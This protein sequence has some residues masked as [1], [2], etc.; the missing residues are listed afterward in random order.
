MDEAHRYRASAGAQAINE[1]AP[2]LGLE[3]TATPKTTGARP[4]PFRNVVYQYPLARALEDG[5]VKTPAVATRTDFGPERCSDAELERIKLEDGVHHHEFVKVELETYAREHGS[6]LVK[7]FMLVVATDT[8]HARALRALIAAPDFFGGR[9]A[10]RV[11]EVHSALRGDESEEFTQRLLEVEHDERTEIVIHVNK[12]KE[13]WDV[14]NLYTIV[15]LRASASEILTEQT[16]GRGLRLPY[17]RRTGVAALDRPTIIAHDRFQ[18]V[19]ERARDAGS[20]IHEGLTI[21]TG[22]DI[23]D[24]Q[25]QRVTT[26]SLA[27]T[28]LTGKGPS[29][30][31]RP[32]ETPVDYAIE[33]PA[34]CRIAETVL[35]R[36]DHYQHLASVHELTRP[37]VRARISAEVGAE[38]APAQEA[39]E[40]FEPVD[41]ALVARVVER[42]TERLAE[43]TIDIPNIVIVPSREVSYGF[44]DFDLEGLERIH[45]P[46]V[47]EEILV[48]RLDT[49][50]RERI[51]RDPQGPREQR[52]EDYLI[53]VL[54]DQDDIDYDA[55]ADLLY[56]LA[57]QVIGR[58]RSYLAGPA[59][60]EQMARRHRT[61]LARF[62][63]GQLREHHW[64][65]PVGS[66]GRVTRGFT[67]LKPIHFTLDAAER[68]RDFRASL[69]SG[70]PV[71]SL[72]FTGFGK[73]CYPH[74]RFQS[75]EGELSFAR[76]LEREPEVLRW[77]KP[78][79]GQFRIEYAGGAYYEPDFV[80]ETTTAKLIVEPKQRGEIDSEE[81]RA[82]AR[83]ARRWLGYANAHAWTCGGKP[84]RYLLVPHD[85]IG[86][87]R[88]LQGLVA[89]FSQ[90]P[91][92]EEDAVVVA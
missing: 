92:P 63:H 78:A 74:Q 73:C 37:E 10:E 77:M 75:A 47:A 4:Q 68:P 89:E 8:E 69:P 52:P 25:P 1:L 67:A 58:L 88:T 36:I 60:V 82:K 62:I 12:L 23:P 7:P 13:G 91:E 49:G 83:A 76:L 9:Y 79:P 24:D 53:A 51:A 81:V 87:N 84:W 85:E 18:E 38:L 44:R 46:P 14:N 66:V 48:Q 42:V 6:P 15:P 21:G 33:D 17:G 86:E 27:E 40:G 64:G 30:G 70:A 90:L 56:K 32:A 50:E 29:V 54:V 41:P 57:G 35:N 80:V 61:E 26:P 45:Y 39:L 2:I 55:H 34:E 65:A 3:L 31:D 20:I 71:R 19:I 72:L 11:I 59:E 16:I 5:F 22:G 43:L 28:L